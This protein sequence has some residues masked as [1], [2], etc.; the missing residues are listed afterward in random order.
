MF[1]SEPAETEGRLIGE[2]GS[3]QWSIPTL[4][5]CLEKVLQEGTAFVDFEVETEL[6]DVGRRRLCLNA[7]ALTFEHGAVAEL[8][9]LGIQEISEPQANASSAEGRL[10]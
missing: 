10:P 6:P 2:L 9:L 3:R 1:R 4:R 5:E 8:I 7:R